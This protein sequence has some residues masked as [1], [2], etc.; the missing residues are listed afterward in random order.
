ME[1]S[2]DPKDFPRKHDL[3]SVC[4]KIPKAH[5]PKKSKKLK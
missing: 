4:V 1:S 2:F 5:L 3:P